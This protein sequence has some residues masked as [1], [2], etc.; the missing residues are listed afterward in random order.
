MVTQLV[1]FHIPCPA[2]RP[3]NCLVWE[4]CWSN[5]RAR[6][7]YHIR[8][9]GDD[10]H[11]NSY[12]HAHLQGA[13][14]FVLAHTHMHTHACTHKKDGQSNSL[15]GLWS[16]LASRGFSAP[17][18][19]CIPCC[20]YLQIRWCGWLLAWRLSLSDCCKSTF[21]GSVMFNRCSWIA[22]CCANWEMLF[23]RSTCVWCIVIQPPRKMFA[24]EV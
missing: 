22:V 1:L 20:V 19:S 13:T 2:S 17:S 15:I 4:L 18:W 8:V 24:Y 5:Y 7:I 16:L 10:I 21:Q 6:G 3:C 14:A 9:L 11:A 12:S 23:P